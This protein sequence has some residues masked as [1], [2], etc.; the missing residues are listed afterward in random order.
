M[1]LNYIKYIVLV[2]TLLNCFYVNGQEN[3]KLQSLD[4][5]IDTIKMKVLALNRD[6]AVLE[7]R[8]YFP[9]ST[10]LNIMVSTNDDTKFLISSIRMSID[11]IPVTSY[12]YNKTEIDALGKG[13][14]QRFYLGNV[15]KGKHQI[16][17][18]IF[19]KIN[20]KNEHKYSESIVIEKQRGLKI[21]E[22]KIKNSQIPDFT[23]KIHK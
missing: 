19:G 20:G 18:T 16:V 17:V 5:R 15:H 13:G 23:F 11:K 3:V 22:L 8:L 9:E 12:L 2:I 7:E 4:E 1:R 14:V 21:I 6:I 10:Q